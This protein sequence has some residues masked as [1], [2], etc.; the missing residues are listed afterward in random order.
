MSHT[1][2]FGS[3]IEADLIESFDYYEEQVDGLGYEF[4]LSVE[5]A[6]YEIERNPLL[7]QKIYKNKRKA[8][9]KRFPFGV[10]Y[11]V[12]KE[13]VLILAVIHLTRDPQIWK[14]RRK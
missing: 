5:A 3:K 13:T 10:F 8:N 2:V 11:I 12:S 6:L 4:L 14:T 7:F 1:I 9:L